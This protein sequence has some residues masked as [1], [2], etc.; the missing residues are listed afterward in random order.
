MRA[1][2]ATYV[3]A[4]HRNG[5]GEPDG[6][7]ADEGEAGVVLPLPHLAG[8]QVTAQVSYPRGGADV[9]WDAGPGELSVTM[10]PPPAACLIQLTT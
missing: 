3:L 5:L 4:W 7:E 8:R 1:P 2:T 9:S 10:G 6:D